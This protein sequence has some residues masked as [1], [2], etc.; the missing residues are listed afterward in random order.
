MASN[1]K[2][3]PHLLVADA[4]GQ[5]FDHP[6][7]LMLSRQGRQFGLPR[8]DD[9]IPL[10]EESR[11]FLLPGRRAM[12]LDPETGE[13][14]VMDETA[15]AA[16]VC[17]GY[18]LTGVA[19]YHSDDGDV[20]TLPLFAYGAVGY[21]NGKFWV[22][23][24]QV[25]TDKR[26]VFTHIPDAR[27]K[28]GAR[29]WLK[30]FPNNRLV[31]HLAG[32]ALTSCC[33]AAR[34]LA[35]GRFEAPLP[36]ARTCNARCLGCISQ[37]PE[38]AGFPATQN[39]IAFTPTPE[40]IVQIMVRHG[41]SEKKP[42]FSFGQGCEGDPMTE[43][44]TIAEA[45]RQY[46]AHPEGAP[47]RTATVNMNTNASLPQH[48]P[49]L[50]EAGLDSMRVSLNSAR[51]ALYEA[52]YR[53]K[54]Y[55]GLADVEASIAAAK[56]AGMFVSLNYL[57]FP[58]VNDTERE[59]EALARLVTT[60]KVDFIQLRNLNLDPEL[61]LDLVEKTLG[62]EPDPCMGLVNFRKRLR[63]DCPWLAFGYFNPYLGEAN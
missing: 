49:M 35:L 29:R 31:E 2:P 25:D 23:A 13:V 38:D 8:P 28:D 21:A 17:P 48:I 42:V 57:F 16:F 26:Q 44:A 5:I 60:H 59:Y 11:I 51:A 24:K 10:P 33:P 37:Q 34:N 32:C 52:Y 46:R 43:A 9:I 41:R 63:K 7:L 40:E 14:E 53:P 4:Q 36:T 3:R 50:A 6:D 27:I 62:T 15:V 20:P 19:A 45:I 1:T 22:A 18:T 47:R 58:G 54:G 12:G 61:Y 39:R 55:D 56:A 30:E